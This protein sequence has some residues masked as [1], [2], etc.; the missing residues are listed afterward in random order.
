MHWKLYHV[1]QVMVLRVKIFIAKD[2][3]EFFHKI[4][5]VFLKNLA[6]IFWDK[7]FSFNLQARILGGQLLLLTKIG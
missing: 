3:F 1:K 2:F 5:P 6:E 4:K 7:K